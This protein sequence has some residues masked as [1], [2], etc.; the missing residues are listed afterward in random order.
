V[1]VARAHG[2]GFSFVPIDPDGAAGL[3]SGANLLAVEI[4]QGDPTSSDISFEMEL[5]A[6]RT[7][8]APFITQEPASVTIRAGATASFRVVASGAADLSYQW[9]HAGTNLAGAIGP[10]LTLDNVQPGQAGAYAVVL[11]NALGA[12]TSLVATLTLLASDPPQL[13][14]DPFQDGAVVR[15]TRLP[16]ASYA[17]EASANLSPGSWVAF[18]NLPMTLFMEEFQLP[19][20]TTNQPARSFRVRTPQSGP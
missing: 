11:T 9:R 12:V 8:L 5:K 6:S 3:L 2:H 10:G 20:W 19:V 17:V 14:T 7:I 1:R 4:H 13:H 16:E 18:T 15:F